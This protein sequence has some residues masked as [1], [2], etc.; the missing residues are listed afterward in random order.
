ML[1]PESCLTSNQFGHAASLGCSSHQRFSTVIDSW[2]AARVFLPAEK[3]HVDERKG[4]KKKK[5]SCLFSAALKFTL[6]PRP[7]E[8]RGL[9]PKQTQ[10]VNYRNSGYH[11][12]SLLLVY[13]SIKC[14]LKNS[15]LF[16]IG[17][18]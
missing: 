2:S 4:K 7:P 15:T 14:T 11:L 9:Q 3:I 17:K 13:I 5:S 16:K 12:D 10:N 6:C 1:V 8:S 18:T